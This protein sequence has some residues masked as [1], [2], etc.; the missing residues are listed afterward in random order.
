VEAVV[1]VLS[2]L[3]VVVII[4]APVVQGVMEQPLVYPAHPSHTQV[5]EAV[6]DIM[7]LIQQVALVVVEQGQVLIQ[8]QQQEHLTQVVE[9]VVE[10]VYPQV[11]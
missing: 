11:D 6:V 4:T 5:V 8:P 1:Q 10:A 3:L 9:A 2:A 7:H